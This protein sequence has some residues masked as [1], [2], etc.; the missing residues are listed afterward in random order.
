MVYFASSVLD[1]FREVVEREEDKTVLQL[2]TEIFR[3]LLRGD[4]PVFNLAMPRIGELVPLGFDYERERMD[5]PS[6]RPDNF[7]D[8]IR[9]ISDEDLGV[10]PRPGTAPRPPPAEAGGRSGDPPPC[11]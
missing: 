3:G 4:R 8:A 11:V 9:R 6:T 2:Q 7:L 5:R 10:A 1:R